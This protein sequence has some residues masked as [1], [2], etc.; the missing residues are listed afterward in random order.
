M[1]RREVY[2]EIWFSSIWGPVKFWGMLLLPVTLIIL[3]LFMFSENSRR[4]EFFSRL[5]SRKQEIINIKLSGAEPFIWKPFLDCKNPDLGQKPGQCIPM[6]FSWKKNAAAKVQYGKNEIVHREPAPG[7]CLIC[8]GGEKENLLEWKF[9]VAKPDFI[10]PGHIPLFWPFS[11]LTLALFIFAFWVHL[12]RFRGV[13]QRLVISS[14]AAAPALLDEES[15]NKMLSQGD[16]FYREHSDGYLR[17]VT[18]LSSYQKWLVKVAGSKKFADIW[19]ALH[20][21]TMAPRMISVLTER[22]GSSPVPMRSVEKIKGIVDRVPPGKVL[23]QK[24]LINEEE[25]RL[26][27]FFGTD[28]MWKRSDGK[29]AVFK[30]LEFLSKREVKEPPNE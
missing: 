7:A 3:S 14:L 6:D 10:F 16:Y 19:D 21:E 20:S 5:D 29:K 12:W 8:H 27:Q 2:S 9:H 4:K 23:L 15:V 18:T 11:M 22:T 24:V 25:G 1:N 28:A 17:W 26:S 13:R 30:S